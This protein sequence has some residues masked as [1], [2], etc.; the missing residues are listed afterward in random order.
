[1]M[2]VLLA[3]GVKLQMTKYE[4]VTVQIDGDKTKGVQLHL[5]D[6]TEETVR[7]LL[8]DMSNFATLG[9][10]SDKNIFVN[11]LTGYQV[12]A[13]VALGDD[14]NTFI[15]TLAQGTDTTS[16]VNALSKQVSDALAT[17]T[18]AATE[19]EK[20]AK[21][22][23]ELSPRMQDIDTERE[24]TVALVEENTRVLNETLE[25]FAK[26]SSTL[27]T[28]LSTVTTIEE[29]ER[30]IEKFLN[31]TVTDNQILR[32]QATDAIERITQVYQNLDS[33]RETYMSRLRELDKIEEDASEA[34][35]VVAT[36]DNNIQLAI[37]K[38]DGVNTTIEGFTKEMDKQKELVEEHGNTAKK[39][40]EDVAQIA[41]RVTALEPITDITALSL[42][43]AK[44]ERIIESEKKLAEFL[45]NN[46]I[47]STCH[48]D[49][50]A[51][52]SITAEKQSYL[53]S[54][55]L[56]ATT[57]ASN[58][59]EYTPSW[60]AV[61]QPCTYDWTI[62]QLQQLAMEIESRVRPIVS[63][64]QSIDR[65]IRSCETM[66]ELVAIQIEYQLPVAPAPQPIVTPVD[67]EEE[68]QEEEV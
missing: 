52:Y 8:S 43:D 51:Q 65:D 11:E 61:G 47:T 44:R 24:K 53:Q 66:E 16:R 28:N 48:G 18:E 46:P 40:S 27:E 6:I 42:D 36:N 58:N 2:K 64:Q 9:L 12:K 32:Q 23:A 29:R 15:I 22:V 17:I 55:I 50:P 67:P 14:E 13:G 68:S 25:K 4:L 7:G 49:A 56:I 21:T 10:Y 31:T 34:R 35:D 5:A 3:N 62:P 45:E 41:D 33:L 39:A 20:C 59:I 57:A 30:S 19:F 1:M 54:M 38:V 63:Q 26:I 37:K 60:N